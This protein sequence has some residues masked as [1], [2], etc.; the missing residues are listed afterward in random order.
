MGANRA[1][2]STAR[3]ARTQVVATARG[4]HALG[5][6]VSDALQAAGREILTASAE[7]LRQAL[8]AER[9]L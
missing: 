4:D 2:S 1:A 3:Y 5:R 9:G 6:A 8:A 7:V